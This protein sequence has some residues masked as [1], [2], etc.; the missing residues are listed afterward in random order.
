M[1]TQSK[2]RV[3]RAELNGAYG[4]VMSVVAKKM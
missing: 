4:K 2:F 3:P 1:T